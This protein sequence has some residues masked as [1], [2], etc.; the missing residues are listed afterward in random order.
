MTVSD[1]ALLDLWESVQGCEPLARMQI[2]LQTALP[3]AA[4]AT[5]D[6]LSIAAC[7]FALLDL[8]R[9][10]FGRYLAGHLDCPHCG[11]ALEFEIDATR[12]SPADG[13]DQAIIAGGLHFR[14]PT[15]SD[16]AAAVRIGNDIDAARLLARRCC[17]DAVDNVPDAT[18]A[19]WDAKLAE[20]EYASAV[21]LQIACVACGAAFSETIDVAAFLWEEMEER[22]SVLFDDIHILASHYGWSERDVLSMSAGRR[23][24]YIQRCDA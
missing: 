22:A 18:V 14:L 21:R 6:A 20:C 16:V 10:V 4:D 7:D 24:I 5:R 1:A 12:F 23:A 17:L 13:S 9:R 3:N 2:L 11:E 8:R 15:T 19:E